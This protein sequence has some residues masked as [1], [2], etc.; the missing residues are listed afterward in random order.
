MNVALVQNAEN[1]VDGYESSQDEDGFIG[2]GLEKSC[3][4][5]LEG[6]L[7]ARRHVQFLLRG[8][9]GVYGVAKRPVGSQIERKSD[10]RKLPLMIERQ[11]RVARVKP[12]ERA[13]RD[14]RAVGRFYINIFQR[15][16]ILLELRVHFE[17]HVILIELSK[18]RGDLPLAK[19]IVKRV[20]NVGGK[21]A[22]ARGGVAVDGDGSD[23]A[24]IQLV[25]GDI[26]KFRKRFQFVDEARSPVS[27]L[28]G[29]NIFKAVLELRA[30]DAVFHSQVLDRLEEERYAID[31]GERGLQAA[32]D[33]G[34]VD[35]APGQRFEIDL[36][37]A[38]VQ[39]GVRAVDADKRGKAFHGLV[40]E[41]H[42]GESLLAAGHGRERNVLRAFRDTQDH[43]GILN[44]KKSFWNVNVKKNCADQSGNRDQESSS[45]KPEHE[46]QRATVE[47]NDGIKSVFGFAVE[48]ALVFFFLMPE[49]LGA[50]HRSQRQ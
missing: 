42:V 34:S 27:K 22:E 40:F 48:P 5:P 37:A 32:D 14:L 38:A 12:R 39:R 1:D 43:S 21:N 36:D 18:N 41:N 45:A 29:V 33:I 47:C 35:V 50:H 19:S 16:R 17:D 49:K 31:F 10:H 15:I 20:V 3:R 44:G 2:Q 25:A 11:S 24:L 23:E 13:E 9:D 4:G 28:L 30:A 26:A 46:L 7:N 6:G 8:V